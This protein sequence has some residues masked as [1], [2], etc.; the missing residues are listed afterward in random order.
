MDLNTQK[1]KDKNAKPTLKDSVEMDLFEKRR[2]FVARG[3]GSIIVKP[4]QN[5]KGT[6]RGGAGEFTNPPEH[7]T[8]REKT[9]RGRKSAK[10]G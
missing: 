3:R 5:S 4:T 1:P 2:I 7:K 9:S 10:A 6:S 8:M